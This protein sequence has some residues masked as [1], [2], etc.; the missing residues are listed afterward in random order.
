[1]VRACEVAP[2]LVQLLPEKC[3]C[4][5]FLFLLTLLFDLYASESE[6]DAS[7]AC[8]SVAGGGYWIHLWRHWLLGLVGRLA[9]W[10]DMDLVLGCR[11]A[12]GVGKEMVVHTYV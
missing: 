2:V 9:Q 3:R 12:P 7:V 10:L 1:M 11:L 8:W 5:S 4:C 6:V